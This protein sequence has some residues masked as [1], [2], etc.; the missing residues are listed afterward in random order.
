MKSNK[1]NNISNIQIRIS[2]NIRRIRNEKKIS[3]EELGF[4][5]NIHR[6]FLWAIERCEKSLSLRSLEKIANGLKVEIIDLFKED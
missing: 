1:V 3:Q 5:S 2:R 6:N 4:R